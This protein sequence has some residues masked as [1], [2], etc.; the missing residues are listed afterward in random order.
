MTTLNIEGMHCE[1]CVA[2]IEK[3]LSAAGITHSVDLTAKT[4]TVE[5]DEGVVAKAIEEMEDLGFGAA[6]SR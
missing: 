3:A 4:V 2:R 1:G 6:V 5:G